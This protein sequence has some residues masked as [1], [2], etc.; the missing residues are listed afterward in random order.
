VSHGQE[1]RGE[2]EAVLD[3]FQS[4]EGGRLLET[5]EV[6]E[7]LDDQIALALATRLRRDYP[8][9]L[10]ASAFSL[11]A[12]RRR[13]AEKF[14]YADRMFFTDEGLQQASSE[15]MGAHVS[16][17]LRDAQ[18]VADLCCGVGGDLISLAAARRV[19]AVDRSHLHVRMALANARVYHQDASLLGVASK[20]EDL[21]YGSFDALYIDPARRVDGQRLAAGRSEPSL[22]WCLALTGQCEAV[23]IKHAPGLA[24]H[25]VP[26][27]WEIEF[28]AEGRR[29]KEALLWSPAVARVRT[30]ATILPTGVS[31]ESSASAPDV[32]VRSPGRYLL[33]PNPAVTRAHLVET[34]AARLNAWKIDDEIGFLSVDRPVHTSFARLLKVLAS[35]P[36]HERR[37]REL[38][39]QVGIGTLDIRRRGL[40]G[41]VD[42]IQ[43]RLRLRGDGRAVLAM[44]RHKGKP[45]AILCVE[46]AEPA[47]PSANE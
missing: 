43:R 2:G 4:P 35:L 11:V 6:L 22:A 8:A 17:R 36:W 42:A 20:A 23:A 18:R 47:Q 29:L 9:A 16:A 10:I 1:I 25:L 27:G 32:P 26:E 3:Y 44:T 28:V 45:W 7:R 12:L 15:R 13:A 14:T 37:L 19:V 21:R 34:L 31:L 30:R 24:H 39:R 38:L 33:D 5:V 41:D 46:V 40:A